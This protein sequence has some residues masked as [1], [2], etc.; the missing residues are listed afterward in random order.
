M[1]PTRLPL[2]ALATLARDYT[3][4]TANES[5]EYTSLEMLAGYNADSEYA[6]MPFENPESDE[7]DPMKRMQAGE[8]LAIQ[9]HLGPIQQECAFIDG[10]PYV[11]T[12]SE[13]ARDED[14]LDDAVA[15]PDETGFFCIGI[16]LDGNRLGTEPVRISGDMSG[17]VCVTKA[18][19]PKSF[20]ERVTAYL[21]RCAGGAP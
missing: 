6:G 10:N 11:A 7:T 20:A 8:R 9:L 5:E 15:F 12:Q 2:E 1:L 4:L 16:W 13:I 19:F 21:R 3:A 14:N 18:V 17:N